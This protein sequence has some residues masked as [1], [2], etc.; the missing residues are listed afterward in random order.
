M[1]HLSDILP[2]HLHLSTVE[3]EVV[4]EEDEIWLS[5]T[6]RKNTV[7]EVMRVDITCLMVVVVVE[8][9]EGEGEG[10]SVTSLEGEPSSSMMVMAS[11]HVYLPIHVVT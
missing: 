3:A 4:V 2:V 5:G 6:A 10:M 8:L 7:K 9:V 11:G 1:S